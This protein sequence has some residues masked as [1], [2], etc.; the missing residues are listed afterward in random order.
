MVHTGNFV[1][2]HTDFTKLEGTL[3]VTCYSS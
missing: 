3:P 2:A 1:S